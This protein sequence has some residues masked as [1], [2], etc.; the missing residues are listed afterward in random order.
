[1]NFS[2]RPSLTRASEPVAQRRLEGLKLVVMVPCL[3]EE[4][5]VGDV[6]SRVPR[7][8]P[9]ICEV[10]VLVVDDGS[11]DATAERAREAGATI[12]HLGRN[13][14]LGMAFRAGVQR[15]L[16]SGAEVVINIDGDGQFNPGD[17][18]KLV[19]PIVAGDAHMVTASRFL[20]DRLVPQM[21]AI[22]RWGNR[23][24][25]WIV[26][27]LTGS[28]YRDVSCGFRAFSREALLRMNL[29]GS[30]TYTQETFL[31]LSFKGMDIREIPVQV[32][33][34]REFGTSR[35]ASNIPRYALRSLQ[36]MLRAFIGYRPFTFFATIAVVFLLA[37]AAL[38]GFLLV[39]YLE[40]GAFSPH[41]WAGFT[42]GSFAFLGV[43][44]LVIGFIGDMMVRLR[45]N[46]EQIL[47]LLKNSAYP[48]SSEAEPSDR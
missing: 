34:T 12:L 7:Q 39:H 22:K 19:A 5:T 29:F 40:T 43:L 35:V 6:V 36:I 8:L 33:G 32:R 31:D 37:G 48:G 1:M 46:Q 10:E 15:C 18:S 9:G 4:S 38:L 47:Y 13:L 28:S 45:M 24:I 11:T 2:R 42:G 26:R 14:G 27:R 25:A 3:N 17:I 23:W 30:F 41:I 16:V 20:D 21:P 44:T